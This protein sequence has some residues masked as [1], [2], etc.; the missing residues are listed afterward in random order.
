VLRFIYAPY[1]NQLPLTYFIPE[2]ASNAKLLTVEYPSAVPALMESGVADAAVLP[3]V[4]VARRPDLVVIDGLGVCAMRKVRS[5]LLKCRTPLRDVRTVAVDPA[6]LTSNALVRV[7]FQNH[8]KQAVRFV[9]PGTGPAPDATVMI[10]DRAL[11]APRA[12]GGDI[13]LAGTWHEMTALPFVFAVWVH[14]RGHIHAQAIARI[15]HAAKRRGVAELPML[16][17]L[18][19]RRLG[20]EEATCLDYL[21]TCIYFDVGDPERRAIRLFW[22]LAAECPVP[23]EDS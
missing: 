23:P 11:C 6:S 7:L 20:L 1:A 9:D 4:E 12:P 13:D 8:W 22:Q 14:R 10:G 17:G 16:A 15:A 5:V 3:V 19:A 18:V 2:V 21:T